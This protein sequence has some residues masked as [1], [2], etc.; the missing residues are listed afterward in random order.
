MRRCAPPGSRLPFSSP[1]ALGFTIRCLQQA[2]SYEFS[3]HSVRDS[4]WIMLNLKIPKSQHAPAGILERGV[5]SLVA[6]D[7]ALDLLIPVALPA[8]RLPLARMTMPERSVDKDSNLPSR[9]RYVD[10]TAW[11]RPMATEAA[12]AVAPKRRSQ[13]PLRAR[14]PTVDARHDPTTSLRR[15]GGRVERV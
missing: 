14:V 3:L 15:G 4:A 5:L 10:A 11:P 13:Q 1:S 7:V 8:V 9:E 12:R 2:S 6:R